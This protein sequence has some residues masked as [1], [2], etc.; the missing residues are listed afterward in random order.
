MYVRAVIYNMH[1]VLQQTESEAQRDFHEL[2][3]FISD[4]EILKLLVALSTSML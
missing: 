3:M 4:V 1:R 2:L